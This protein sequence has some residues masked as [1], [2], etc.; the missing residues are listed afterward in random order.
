MRASHSPL[1]I[2]LATGTKFHRERHNSSSSPHAR[3]RKRRHFFSFC[4]LFF[5]FPLSSSSSSLISFSSMCTH[6]GEKENSFLLLFLMHAHAHKGEE[7][8]ILLLL[9]FSSLLRVSMRPCASKREKNF[10]PLSSS[11]L[12]HA[13]A[14]VGERKRSFF[15]ASLFISSFLSP[16][17]HLLLLILWD[18]SLSQNLLPFLV[19]MLVCTRKMRG[20]DLLP[21]SQ[22]KIIMSRERRKGRRLFSSILT[23]SR[24]PSLHIL[25]LACK[26]TAPALSASPHHCE[27][28]NFFSLFFMCAV[29]SS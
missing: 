9:C 21:L 25:S 6:K 5:F 12:E 1:H 24:T 27:E 3:V 26:K 18:G 17:S 7:E 29:L 4:L 23:H 2:S 20:R 22:R 14:C 16:C 8:E 28:N 11:L 19:C 15:S 13:C 10:L